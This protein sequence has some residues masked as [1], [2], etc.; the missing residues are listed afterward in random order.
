MRLES[1]AL[2]IEILNLQQSLEN[3]VSILKEDLSHESKQAE[4]KQKMTI[5]A[6]RDSCSLPEVP[7]SIRHHPKHR[8]YA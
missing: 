3:L 2:L 8:Y 7:K 5:E 6:I 4:I 1:R